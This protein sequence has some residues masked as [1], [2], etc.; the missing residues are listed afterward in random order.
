VS[1]REVADEPTYG[2]GLSCRGGGDVHDPAGRWSVVERCDIDA[3][4]RV[5]DAFLG[6]LRGD[7]TG[8]TLVRLSE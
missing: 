8:K 2:Q 4:V 7:T 1:L 3:L 5:G 6:M